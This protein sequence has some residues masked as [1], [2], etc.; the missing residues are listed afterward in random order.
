MCSPTM[1]SCEQVCSRHRSDITV[2]YKIA[3]AFA[4]ACIIGRVWALNDSQ[5][6]W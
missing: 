5:K 6:M 1:V 2:G 3:G 4:Y